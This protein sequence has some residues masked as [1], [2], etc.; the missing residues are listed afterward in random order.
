MNRMNRYENIIL[1]KPIA[2]EVY[3]GSYATSI[4]V[5]ELIS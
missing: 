2:Y 4:S 1:I 5:E 3:S